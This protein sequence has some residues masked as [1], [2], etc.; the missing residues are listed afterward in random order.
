[1]F[2][3]SLFGTELP[4]ALR[5]II[6]FLL[7]LG[8]I[9]ATTWAV[10][11]FGGGRLG[12]ATNRGRQP[13]LAVID[14]APVDTRRR[15]ILIRRDN[16]EHLLMIGG[17]TDIVVEANIVRAVASS[18][19]APSARAVASD[20]TAAAAADNTMWPLQPETMT[21]RAP[22]AAEE[23]WQQPE[24]APRQRSAEPLAGLAAELSRPVPPAEPRE[25]K[26]S[27]ERKTRVEAARATEAEPARATAAEPTRTPPQPA[28]VA[29]LPAPADKNL[30]EMAQRLEAALRRPTAS[31]AKPAGAVD[32]ESKSET[33]VSLAARAE[34]G[35]GTEKPAR[36]AKAGR[37]EP[38]PAKGLYDSLEQ[39]MASLLGRPAA[40]Q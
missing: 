33:V 12:V 11:R 26:P 3:T 5:V 15:L 22:R 7:V 17:P 21:P 27:P 1:M 30:A 20:R 37:G 24:P 40:R 13:R 4:G 16:I 14:A 28:P 9:G 31:A 6:V 38:K 19:E 8:L 18:R 32:P 35:S 29:E 34:A 2:D 36:E 10:R 39:E 25:A 23:P